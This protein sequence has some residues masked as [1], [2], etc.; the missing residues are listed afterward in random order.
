MWVGDYYPT[1]MRRG[2][3]IGLSVQTLLLSPPKLL[4]LDIQASEQL[5]AKRNQ[6]VEISKNWLEYASN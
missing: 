2:K 6:S 4:D 5:V 3:I 1:R